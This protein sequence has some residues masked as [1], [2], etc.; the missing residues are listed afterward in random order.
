MSVTKNRVDGQ[1]RPVTA[2]DPDNG[3][4]DELR[5]VPKARAC[6]HVFYVTL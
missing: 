5:R 3:W 6:I 1:P 4:V 2:A